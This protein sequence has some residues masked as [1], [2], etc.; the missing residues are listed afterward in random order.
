MNLTELR[1]VGKGG[2]WR[3]F[4]VLFENL[5]K[6][7]KKS[8]KNRKISGKIWKISGKIRKKPKKIRKYPEKSGKNSEKIQKIAIFRG[9]RSRAPRTFSKPQCFTRVP[10][11]FFA[12]A[13]FAEIYAIVT[14]CQCG[15]SII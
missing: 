4:L 8:G 3:V 13:S 15:I 11:T 10:R 2:F 14:M 5:V 1:V 12:R 9:G 6:S 7:A